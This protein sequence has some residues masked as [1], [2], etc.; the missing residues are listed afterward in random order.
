MFFKLGTIAFGGPAAHIAMMDDEV[1]KRR[2]WFDREKLLDLIGVT[3]LLTRGQTLQNWPST[4]ATSGQDGRG[5]LWRA[6]ALF[7]Q[8]W[9]WCGFWP[10]FTL[11]IA[12][13]RKWGWLLYGIKPVI[14]AI[15]LQA[16]WKLGKKAIKDAPTVLAAMGVIV[17]YFLGINEIVLL[18][19]GGLGG[20]GHR[21]PEIRAT[22]IPLADA[23]A[24]IF[25]PRRQA[26]PPQSP[27]PSWLQVFFIFPQDWLGVVRQWIC[28]AGV[29][30]S[31]IWWSGTNG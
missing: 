20:D 23:L 31:G 5:Y 29:F 21:E 19:P 4:L 28:A 10:L 30:Y 17:G 3:N 16:L 13:C 22:G 26:R 18:A 8:P 6:V 14:M 25:W 2:Q 15:I 1:V 7:F 12:P 27:S 9:S 24:R 11:N